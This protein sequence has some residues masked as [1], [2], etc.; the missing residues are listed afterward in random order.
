MSNAIEL[1]DKRKTVLVLL[2]GDI[3]YDSRVKKIVNSLTCTDSYKVV[4]ISNRPIINMSEFSRSDNIVEIPFSSRRS[5]STK[6]HGNLSLSVLNK[7]LKFFLITPVRWGKFFI[8]RKKAMHLISKYQIR[9]DIVHCNDFITLP[10]GIWL[11]KNT[12]PR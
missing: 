5:L 7:V 12:Q 6:R 2:N 9:P 10:L 11:K 1:A 8:W 3:N 4:L